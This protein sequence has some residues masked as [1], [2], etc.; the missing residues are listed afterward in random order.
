MSAQ[1]LGLFVLG[2]EPPWLYTEPTS[3]VVMSEALV[4]AR[5]TC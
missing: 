1:L 4:L 2:P 3:Y 5:S